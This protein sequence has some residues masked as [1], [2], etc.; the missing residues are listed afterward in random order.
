MQSLL[1]PTELLTLENFHSSCSEQRILK[2]N[3]HLHLHNA[4]R[5]YNRKCRHEH[6]KSSHSLHR[7]WSWR[8]SFCSYMQQY[9]RSWWSSWLLRIPSCPHFKP[10]FKL[11]C[12][13]STRGMQ[14]LCSFLWRTCYGTRTHGHLLSSYRSR[15]R[16]QQYGS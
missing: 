6:P 4:L 2:L 3:D 12:N 10:Y 5:I 14:I 15:F 11:V 13:S 8:L 7:Q 16:S 9:S 1:D